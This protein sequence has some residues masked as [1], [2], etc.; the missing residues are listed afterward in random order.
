MKQTSTNS[1]HIIITIGIP[2]AGKSFFA[3]HFSDTFKAPIIS[4]EQLYKD[5]NDEKLI[6]K[7]SKYLLKELL[8]TRQTIIYDGKT[9]STSDRDTVAKLAIKNGYEPLFVWIQTEISIAKKRSIKPTDDKTPITAE[10]FDLRLKSFNTPTQKEKMIVISG[11][12]D[13]ASQLKIV[14]KHLADQPTTTNNER[15]TRYNITR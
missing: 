13:H 9:D 12:Q 5:F 4:H 3:E 11:K 8:K 2:G 6:F 7:I 1:P 15:V 10:Q 14:L